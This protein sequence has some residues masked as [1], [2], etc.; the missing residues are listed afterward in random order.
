ML[1]CCF[2]LTTCHEKCRKRLLDSAGGSWV[3]TAEI[4]PHMIPNMFLAP[5]SNRSEPSSSSSAAAAGSACARY[6]GR[7]MRV[8]TMSF[9]VNGRTLCSKCLRSHDSG[10]VASRTR[11]ILQW[12]QRRD[13]LRCAQ[14]VNIVWGSR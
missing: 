9:I 5:T 14:C 1:K 12:K 8:S 10:S 11:P 3:P 13:P 6:L 2:C 7:R 4:S